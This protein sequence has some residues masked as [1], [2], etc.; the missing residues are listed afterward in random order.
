M[1]QAYRD[2][3]DVKHFCGMLDGLAFLPLADVADGIQFLKSNTPAVDGLTDLVS[4]FE[5]TYV[6]GH[7]RHVRQPGAAQQ[8]VVRFR[9]HP[10]LF[11][12]EVWNVHDATLQ[13][14]DR[15]NNACEA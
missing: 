11:P 2:R 12:P 4:Y 14:G 6:T 9:R 15:T 3:D 10:P 13:N 5:M 7:F 1:T 8:I